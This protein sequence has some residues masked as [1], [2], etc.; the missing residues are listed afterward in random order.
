M[1]DY[2]DDTTPW[3]IGQARKVPGPRRTPERCC[4]LSDPPL[5]LDVSRCTKHRRIELCVNY[6]GYVLTDEQAMQLGS[7][8]I[9]AASGER[10]STEPAGDLP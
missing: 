6:V 7:A 1:S 2:S 9:A 8:L 4:L 3:Q 10:G 5:H